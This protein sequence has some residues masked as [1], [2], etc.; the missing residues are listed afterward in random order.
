MHSDKE[1]KMDKL[2]IKTEKFYV[3]KNKESEKCPKKLY[4]FG[5]QVIGNP[6]QTGLNRKGD[7]VSHLRKEVQ[8]EAV[9][10]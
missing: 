1:K 4:Q 8:R 9:P 7:L 5:L 2:N 3:S 6:T 10:S